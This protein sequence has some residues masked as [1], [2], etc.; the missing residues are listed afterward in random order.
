VLKAFPSPRSLETPRN[1]KLH[2]APPRSATRSS[3]LEPEILPQNLFMRLLRMERKRTERSRRPFV[4]M[5]LESE[6]LFQPGAGNAA[7]DK[8][9]QVLA[10][11]TRATD[12][13]GWY[14]EA[15]AIGVI[16]TEIGPLAEASSAARILRDKLIRAISDALTLDEF[17]QIGLSF[18]VFPENWEERGPGRPTDSILYPDLARKLDP[19]RAQHLVKRAMDIAGSLLALVLLSPLLL[20]IALAIKLTSKGPVIF[21]Q[22]RLGRNG[23]RFEFLKFRS[24]HVSSDPKVHEEYVRLFISGSAA[25]GQKNGSQAPVYK[26]VHDP[27]VTPLGRFLRRS[28]LDELPQLFNV[29]KGDMSLVGP[30]PPVP[31]EATAY[32]L[33]HKDRL[34][35]ATPGI[36]GLW[37]VGGRSRVKFDDMVRMDLA[38]ARSWSLWLD[39]KILLRTP[40]AVLR[41]EGAY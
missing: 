15:S 34:R 7:L 12:V 36:T 32:D 30:R 5:L 22:E 10:Y 27:R 2:P 21:R 33:W 13:T 25:A 23:V 28:S 6:G 17:N 38:Y 29:L 1:G 35:A 40:R 18:H 3:R 11:S 14:Q 31:Y 41:R 4:L 8:V 16:F 9:L 19:K 37:Q 24:M 39:L 26:M 20:L